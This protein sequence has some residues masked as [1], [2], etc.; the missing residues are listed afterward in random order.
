MGQFYVSIS[1]LGKATLGWDDP[2]P[3]IGFRPHLSLTKSLFPP[4]VHTL[5]F[6][7]TRQTRFVRR[8]V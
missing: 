3:E 1:D 4:S 6:P 8:Q 5:T 2:T 7:S